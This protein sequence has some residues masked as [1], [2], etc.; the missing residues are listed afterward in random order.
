MKLAAIP[1]D[2]HNPNPLQMENKTMKAQLNL[3]Y[4]QKKANKQKV[5]QLQQQLRTT[6]MYAKQNK[7]QGNREGAEKHLAVAFELLDSITGL[8]RRILV[9]DQIIEKILKSSS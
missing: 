9:Q 3:V 2:L 7:K 4:E 1:H 5:K 6:T 8:K